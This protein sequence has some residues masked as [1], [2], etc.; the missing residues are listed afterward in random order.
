MTHKGTQ[1]I[2]TPRLVLRKYSLSD[3]SDIYKNYATDERVTKF[4]SW[5]PYNNI[6]EL[7][8][9]INTQI[10]GYKINTTYNWVIE[11]SNAAVGSI[12]VTF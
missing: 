11:Y 10:S 1:T 7:E 8:N 4:L 3:A 5:L 12:S 9:F 2:K 6:S